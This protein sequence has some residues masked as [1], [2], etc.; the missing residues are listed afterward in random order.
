MFYL[1]LVYVKLDFGPKT[2]RRNLKGHP[3]GSIIY[4]IVLHSACFIL[5]NLVF[6]FMSKIL[7]G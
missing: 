2:G 4:A 7:N 5:C 1:L 3:L 6:N